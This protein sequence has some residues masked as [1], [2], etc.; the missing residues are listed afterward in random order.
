[1]HPSYAPYDLDIPDNERIDVWLEEF[2]RFEKD[3]GLPALNIVR[4]GNDHTHGTVPGKPT[5]RAYVAENDL[6]LGRLVEAVSRSRF[7]PESAILVLEDDAQNGP[8]HVDA[9]RSVLLVASPWAKRGAVDSTLYTTSGVL[10]TIELVLGLPPMSQYDAAATPLFAAFAARP[11]PAPYTARPARV[12]LTETNG[13]DAPGAQA[14]LRMNMIE[15][16]LAPERELNEIIWKSIR[17]AVSEMPAPIR[18]AFIRP[19]AEE[20]EDGEEDEGVEDQ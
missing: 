3:G 19:I 2:R 1:V 8:D 11:D 17:G 12:S 18:A 9:H 4:L 6:A 15:A 13:P 5:P 20:A 10:R 7:W 14:S 16:D